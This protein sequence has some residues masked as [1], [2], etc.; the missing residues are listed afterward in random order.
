M[1]KIFISYRREDTKFES[2]LLY[3]L[4][5][6]EFGEKNVFIDTED[7]RIGDNWVKVLEN[8][9]QKCDVLI[10][11]IGE[12]WTLLKRNGVRRL[13]LEDDWVRNEIA[14]C[15]RRKVKVYPILMDYPNVPSLSQMNLP[16]EIEELKD[17]QA[18]SIREGRNSDYL[19]LFNSLNIA[20]NNVLI[21]RSIAVV[22]VL[23][24]I[25]SLFFVLKDRN[26]KPKP[27][28]LQRSFYVEHKVNIPD[29]LPFH[30]SYEA[31]NLLE[32]EKN[33]NGYS[34]ADGV[35]IPTKW[36]LGGPHNPSLDC[37]LS[38]RICKSKEKSCDDFTN[39]EKCDYVNDRG[40]NTPNT[41]QWAALAESD[42][43]L[44]GR[45][46]IYAAGIEGTEKPSMEKVS[47]LTQLAIEASHGKIQHLAIPLIGAGAGAEEDKLRKDSSLVA[48]INGIKSCKKGPDTVS[49]ILFEDKEFFSF[50]NLATV[51]KM[52][53]W[54]RIIHEMFK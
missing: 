48:V 11:M 13:D 22:S 4:L 39:W 24:F 38:L 36:N 6:K 16:N 31:A 42:V 40:L 15:L 1:V 37:F 50:S 21:K 19:P 10:V 32:D 51:E 2:L 45:R 20:K 23:V 41:A 30:V 54:E 49:I 8:A 9:L 35:V 17:I 52:Q 7:I 3:A 28:D 44:A 18:I 12:N 29:S 34:N 46:V 25:M 27:G 53:N 47:T 33:A 26:D 43:V 14:I 5:A